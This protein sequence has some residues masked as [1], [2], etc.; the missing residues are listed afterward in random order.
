MSDTPAPKRKTGRPPGTIN[1]TSAAAITKAAETGLLPH[2]ILLAF[3]RGEMFIERTVNPVT[4]EVVEHERYPDGSMRLTAANMAAPYFAPKLA[5]VQHK[6][7]I[8]RT[9]DA[10]SDDELI[11]VALP[12]GDDDGGI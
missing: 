12:T 10:V 5:Q 9:A 7:S 1:K 2:E 6:G 11:K 3:A 8:A 4:K